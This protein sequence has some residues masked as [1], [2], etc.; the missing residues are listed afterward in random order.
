MRKI[1]TLSIALLT[2][3]A[4]IIF[5]QREI[6]NY[7]SQLQSS[8]KEIVDAI[9]SCAYFV[10]FWVGAIVISICCIIIHFFNNR[11]KKS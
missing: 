10:G 5:L 1:T 7:Q 11:S 3:V 4:T 2:G 6:V 9:T 8:S